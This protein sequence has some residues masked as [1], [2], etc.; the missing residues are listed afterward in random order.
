VSKQPLFSNAA[1][2]S[3]GAGFLF[4]G[5]RWTVVIQPHKRTNGASIMIWANKDWAVTDNGLESRVPAVEY[6][7]LKER[8]CELF[9]GTANISMWPRHMVQKRWVDFDL[10]CSAYVKAV[11]IH[12]PKGR[13][14]I[15]LAA[16]LAM[17]EAGY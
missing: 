6:L 5:R 3:V 8:L 4:A 7:I 1:L 11:E 10:F 17:A 2:R 13:D 15:D 14:E 16:S 9:S 12:T